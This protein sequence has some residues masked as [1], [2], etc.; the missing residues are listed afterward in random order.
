MEGVLQARTLYFRVLG[1]LTTMRVRMRVLFVDNRF[2]ASQVDGCGT[3]VVG[4]IKRVVGSRVVG[5][6]HFAIFPLCFRIVAVCFVVR[7]SFK[8]VGFEEF[9]LRQGGRNSRL[10]LHL[11]ASS[12]LRVGKCAA[13]NGSRG[14]GQTRSFGW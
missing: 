11:Q 7:G 2:R 12:I 9:L 13:G 4:I 5:R 3:D 10:N 14:G 8:G 6:A 1:R